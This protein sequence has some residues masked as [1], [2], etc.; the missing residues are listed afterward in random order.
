[1]WAIP[2]HSSKYLE[3]CLEPSRR[4]DFWANLGLFPSC[5]ESHPPANMVALSIN[6]K[7]HRKFQVYLSTGPLGQWAPTW[8]WHSI[9]TSA[10]LGMCAPAIQE[11]EKCQKSQSC[12][13]EG[14]LRLETDT[15]GQDAKA[16]AGVSVPR[17]VFPFLWGGVANRPE[18]SEMC[19]VLWNPCTD[20]PCPGPES[21]RNVEKR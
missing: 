2:L 6:G 12:L 17:W 18:K 3:R 8:S 5:L 1:M 14:G 15:W 11:E 13:E 7:G 16:L 20:L 4:L 21:E 9:H 10:G 19:C